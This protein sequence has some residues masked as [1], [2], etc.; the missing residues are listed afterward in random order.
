MRF[1]LIFQLNNAEF[2]IDK[3]PC[4][5]SF[6]KKSL[7]EYEN[8]EYYDNYFA[9][10]AQKNYAFSVLMPDSVFHKEKIMVPR[11][12]IKVFFSS[13]D[14]NTAIKFYNSFLFQKNKSFQ[15]PLNNAMTL[16]QVNM[17]LEKEIKS[18]QILIQM[19]SPLCLRIHDRTS[20]QDTYLES[21]DPGFERTLRFIVQNQVKIEEEITDEMVEEFRCIPFQAKKNSCFASW[22]FITCNIGT[23]GLFG[24]PKLLTY[25]YRNGLGSRK[26]GGFGLF[27]IMKQ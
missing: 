15:L 7:S 4:F 14:G 11:K 27:Q 24:N 19:N 26:N 10:A 2:P 12:I 23:F 22:Q 18:N 1:S 16:T 13:N 3:N 6:F 20:N 21:S 9:T 25:L 17:E 8:G 5:I